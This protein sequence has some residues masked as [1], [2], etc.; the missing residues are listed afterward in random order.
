MKVYI[1]M[2]EPV[3]YEQEPAI[4][5]VFKSEESAI[6]YVE[7]QNLECVGQL[8]RFNMLWQMFNQDLLNEEEK[9]EMDWLEFCMERCHEDICVHEV[10]E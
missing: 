6:K 10:L 4:R 7:E 5:A 1:V 2:S 9:R 3:T 8:A